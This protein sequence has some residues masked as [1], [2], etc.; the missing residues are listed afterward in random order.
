MIA[1]LL[2]AEVVLGQGGELEGPPTA[3]VV[4]EGTEIVAF[5]FAEVPIKSR[6]Q[7]AL[8]LADANARAELL[9][10]VRAGVAEVQRDVQTADSQQIERINAQVASGVLPALSPA[11]HGWRKLQRDG[12]A[13]LQVWSRMTAQRGALVEALAKVLVRKDL[14]AAAAARVGAGK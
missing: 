12:E 11:R 9:A 2:A 4:S 10:A 14:A 7:A 6:L 13:V 5:G 3:T 8:A 1:L